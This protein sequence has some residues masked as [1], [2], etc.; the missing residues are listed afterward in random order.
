M[1]RT[2]K[3]IFLTVSLVA[4]SSLLV[5]AVGQQA[6][7]K[8]IPLLVL[9]ILLLGVAITLVIKANQGLRKIAQTS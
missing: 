3:C 1:G 8:E 9:T 4:V 5:A 7:G 2:R 6:C